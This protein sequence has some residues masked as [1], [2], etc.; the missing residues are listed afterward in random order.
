MGRI[1]NAS[2]Y[3]LPDGRLV[4]RIRW[5]RKPNHDFVIRVTSNGKDRIEFLDAW[6]QDN[7][8][9]V[10]KVDPPVGQNKPHIRKIRHR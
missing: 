4:R 2:H 3:E 7:A 9:P 8:I 1:S 5:L 10:G 6:F